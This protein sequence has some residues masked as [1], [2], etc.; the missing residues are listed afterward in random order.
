MTI[1]NGQRRTISDS[2]GL[3]LLHSRLLIICSAK[4]KDCILICG[5]FF[6]LFIRK[7]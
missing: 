3:E 6:T 5:C 4:D 7:G 2:G 1:R